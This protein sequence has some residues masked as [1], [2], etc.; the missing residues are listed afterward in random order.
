MTGELFST[1]G[2]QT[3]MRCYALPPMN[4]PG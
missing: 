2:H 1:A 3:L 4:D